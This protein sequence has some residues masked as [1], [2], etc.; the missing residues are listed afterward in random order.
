MRRIGTVMSQGS[1][2]IQVAHAIAPAPTL[3]RSCMKRVVALAACTM[4]VLPVT[5]QAM[6]NPASVFCKTM[7]GRSVAATLADGSAIGL[8][9]L[10]NRKIVEEWTLFRMFDGKKPAS[11][12]NPFR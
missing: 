12:N 2:G 5:A 1:A 10:P 11:R 8:C 9:Y 3:E 4:A 7:G 6:P